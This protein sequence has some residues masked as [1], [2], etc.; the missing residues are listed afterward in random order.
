MYSYQ[1]A[2]PLYPHSQNLLRTPAMVGGREKGDYVRV[3]L[4]VQDLRSDTISRVGTAHR[5]IYIADKF[6]IC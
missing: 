1:K 3:Q 5:S 2:Y 4:L 6:D